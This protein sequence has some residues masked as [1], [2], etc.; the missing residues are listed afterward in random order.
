MK[1][2]KHVNKL[3]K[4]VVPVFVMRKRKISKLP[5]SLQAH[6]RDASFWFRMTLAIWC[7]YMSAYNWRLSHVDIMVTDELPFY[8]V[9]IVKKTDK[10]TQ[11]KKLFTFTAFGPYN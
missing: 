7:G 6:E 2:K 8:F 10:M 4:P 1:P 11:E 9:M 3:L 5:H